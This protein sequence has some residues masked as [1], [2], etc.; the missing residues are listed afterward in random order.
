MFRRAIPKEIRCK[1]ANCFI[2]RSEILASGSDHIQILVVSLAQR[3]RREMCTVCES[4]RDGTSET[5]RRERGAGECG[6]EERKM[7]ISQCLSE[8][9]DTLLESPSL[10]NVN[11]I[12]LCTERE[13]GEES[14][15]NT[16]RRYSIYILSIKLTPLQNDVSSSLL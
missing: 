13:G 5:R 11:L 14:G 9:T 12:W 16:V 15:E 4:G 2:P 3:T 10:S 6:K 7:K 1:Y 8:N